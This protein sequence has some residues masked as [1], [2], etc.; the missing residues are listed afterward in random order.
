MVRNST[1]VSFLRIGKRR[2][3]IFNKACIKFG[4]TVV[5]HTTQNSFTLIDDKLD[6]I[7]PT[8]ALKSSSSSPVFIRTQWL[9]DLIKQNK[10][11]PYQ[12][13]ILCATPSQPV[14]SLTETSY[15]Q[16]NQVQNEN[17]QYHFQ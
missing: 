6:F 11:L 7:S 12:S 9:S 10:L 14:P 16:D 5:D 2:L 3:E 17:V 8:K 1:S 13:Y 4:L 15:Q